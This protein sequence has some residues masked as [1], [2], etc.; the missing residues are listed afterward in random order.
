MAWPGAGLC[1]RRLQRLLARRTEREPLAALLGIGIAVYVLGSLLSSGA[2]EPE[3]QPRR[4]ST[5]R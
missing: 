3:P 4:R 1:P 5:K 2:S